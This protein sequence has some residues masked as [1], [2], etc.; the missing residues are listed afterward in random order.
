M[1][2]DDTAR[3]TVL[4]LGLMGQ[5]LSSTLAESG[6]TVTVWN[7]TPGKAAGL[8]EQG[9]T[10][11]AT[12]GEAIAASPLVVAVLLD[13]DSVHDA[14]DPYVE[15]LSGRTL[16]NLTSTSPNQ[17]RELARWAAANDIPYLDGGIMASPDMIGGPDSSILYS[18]AESVYAKHR[19]LLELW[20]E[21]AYFGEDP[22]LASLW[23]FA[24]LSTMYLTFAAF[25]HGAAL[26][27][28]AGVPAA[29]FATRALPWL[30]GSA[31]TIPLQAAG[32]DSGDYTTDVQHLHFTKA[33]ADAI[34]Q[35]AVEQGVNPAMFEHFKNL[36]DR[37]VAN[38]H[39]AESFVRIFES[40]KNPAQ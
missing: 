8:T 11:A 21:A 31:A 9:I 5:A 39:G 13:H 29:E 26:V 28:G 35:T 27:S 2:V 24:L 23:D 7:R 25:Y 30:T 20:G 37:H 33:A 1:A 32:M 22:G 34:H 4:G 12:L 19:P 3:V 15:A 10:E 38:G 6:H 17:A 36:V 18:G 40:F 14:L 16:I